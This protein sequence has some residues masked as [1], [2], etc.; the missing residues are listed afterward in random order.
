[1]TWGLVAGAAVGLVGSGLQSR[2]ARR[3]A[4]AQ[5]R[6]SDAATAEQRRQYD[7]TRTDQMPWLEAG[8]NALGQMQQL[9]SGDFSSFRESPDYRF[10]FDQGQQGLDR[11]AAARG[12]LY[13]GGHTADTIKFGQGMASQQYGAF[14]D[15]LASMAGI[16]QSTAR[17]L[18]SLGAG[19]ASQIG[20]NY[21]GAADARASSYG[22]RANVWGQAAAGVGNSFG[23]WYGNNSGR[24][25]GGTGFYF[26]K[27]PGEG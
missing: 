19:M 12:G 23:Q 26:G 16:G 21:R 7:Q 20:A 14:Y 17:G 4:N 5:Q 11:G 22:Q 1:M 15:R 6:G 25:S 10:A 24:N 3:G 9:N 2:A 18:G 27:K 8:G 13:G